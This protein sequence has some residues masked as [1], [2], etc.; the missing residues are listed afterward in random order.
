VVLG[1]ALDDL[2][3]A[4]RAQT[5]PLRIMGWP[6][7]RSASPPPER[8]SDSFGPRSSDTDATVTEVRD[9]Y[10]WEAE[11]VLTPMS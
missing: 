5:E 6:T 1:P 9:P 4:H 10:A 11:L 7:D 2:G 3:V 8:E